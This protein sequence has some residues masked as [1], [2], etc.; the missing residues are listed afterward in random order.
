MNASNNRKINFVYEWIG[1]DGPLTNNRVPTLM[2]FMTSSFINVDYAMYGYK[3]DLRQRPHFY[4]KFGKNLRICS[5]SNIPDEPFFYEL[6]F[7][8][9]HYRD[10]L[11][12]FHHSNGLL[13]NN[14]ISDTVA[15]KILKKEGYILI[16][17]LHEGYMYDEFLKAMTDYFKG[18]GAPLS[19]IVYVS[20][21]QNG[22]EIYKDFCKQ[23]NI[24]EEI[25]IEYFPTF[26]FDR[27]D[28]GDA[29]ASTDPY[30]PGPRKKKFLCF[31]RRYNEHRLLVYLDFFKRNLLEVTY[32]SMAKDQ[33]ESGRPF[34]ENASHVINLHKNLGLGMDTVYDSSVLLPLTLDTPDFSKYPMEKK[35]SEVNDFYKNSYINIVTETYFFNNIRHITEKTYKPIAFMQPF[36]IFAAPGT[37]GHLK[38][39]GFKTF[40]EFWDES[41][42]DILDHEKRFSFI[43]N[44]IENISKWPE[45]KLI[46][47]TYKLKDTLEFNRNHL[48]TMGNPEVE[49]LLN[50]YGI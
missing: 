32:M 44:L 35:I 15:Q 46:D 26:R 8:N 49:Y 43:M 19:Q 14:R 11:G 13:D 31:N 40:S 6:N 48:L 2:D 10:I 9:Y 25:K 36:I 50:T 37:L 5:P 47:L 41:Y 21:C 20:N 3:E 29:L 33:P 18:K 34:I 24:P 28:V 38:E 22:K 12:A 4:N 16:T 7:T 23:Y 27:C 1:P 30:V 17:L 45:S 42:D 39:S